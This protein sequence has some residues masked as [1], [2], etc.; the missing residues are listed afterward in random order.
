M[1]TDKSHN[2]ATVRATP[3]IKSTP[4]KHIMRMIRQNRIV[5]VRLSRK[6]SPY[7]FM[8][9]LKSNSA[10]QGGVKVVKWFMHNNGV[11]LFGLLETKLKPGNLLKKNTSICDGW[12]VSTNCSWHK[13]GRIWVLWKP[14]LFDIQFLSYSAQ[15]IHMLVHSQIDDKRFYLTFIYSYNDLN[16]RIELWHFLKKF[17][18]ECNAPWLWLGDFNTVLSPVER[19]GGSTSD[20]EMEHFQDCVSICCMEDIAATVALFTWSNKQAP[21]DRVYSRLDRAM[22]NQEWFEHFGDSVAHFHPEGL[23]ITVLV[24]LWTGILR[25]MIGNVSSILTC[26]GLHQL[27][28]LLCLLVGPSPIRKALIENP[29]DATLLQQELDLAHDLKD[30]ITARDSF[31]IQKVKVQWSLEGDLNTSYFHHSIKKRVM[32]KKVF[33]IE[34]KDGILCTDGDA[35]QNA[36]LVYYQELLG[37]HNTTDAV[38]INVVKQGQ[39]YNEAHWLLMSSPVTAEEVKKCL[40]NIPASKSPGPHGYS[41]QFYRDAWDIVGTE[42]CE[43]VINFFDTGKLLTQINATVITLIPKIDRPASVKHYRP[44]SCC[45]VLYKVISMLLCSRMALVLPDLISKTQG[46]FVKGR[47]I[48]ENILICQDLIRQY[49]RG[50]ASP[51]CLFKLDLQKAYDSIEWAFVDQMLEALHLPEKFRRMIMLC[52]TT[53][54]YTLNLNGAQFGYFHGRRGLRQG[55]PISL[56]IFCI[57]MEYLSRI[58]EYATRKCKGDVKSIMLILR[59]LATFS[60]SSGLKVNASNSEVVYNWVSDS[61]KH[62]IAQVSGFQEGKL[63]FKYLGIPIQ[64]GRLTRADCNILLENIISRIRGIG[65]RK[66][67]YAG[68]LVLINSVLNTLHNYW[69]SIFLIP[70]GVIKRLKSICRNF[71]WCGGSNYNRAPLVA[72]QNVCCSK[73]EGGLGIKEA[74]VWNIASVGKLVNWIYTKADR[75]WVLWIDHVYMKGADWETY[76]PPPDSNWNWRNICKVKDCL[77]GGYQGNCWVASTGGYSISAGYHCLQALHPP[78]PLYHDVWYTWVLPKQAFIGWL[79]HR[80]APNTRSKLCKLG[81]SS[82]ANCVVCEM[83]EETHDH[84]FWDCAYASKIIAGLENWLQLKLNDQSA[85]YSKLQKRV[86]RVVKMAV[87]YAIWMERNSARLELSIC[88]PEKL[89]QQVQNQVHGRLV[90]KL[91]NCTMPSECS[92][93]STINIRC[94][95][96]T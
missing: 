81:L 71:L 13:G 75:L 15:H 85:S 3:A 60:G 16:G 6:F 83:G 78:V 67:S 8:D 82:T 63:P 48:L 26:R 1:H 11:G 90:E 73:K 50:K 31:L 88:R 37:T 51:R 38:N 4:A 21:V 66:L 10:T 44:I 5:G 49:S 91:R 65:A 14:S 76:H 7:T 22:G 28:N 35:I 56:L 29:S 54:T 40:F 92:W 30:L 41:S 69:A 19:L 55:D 18:E 32:M 93:L 96:C 70:K 33:Q 36:F 64:H 79:I 89:I 84:L 68:R 42:I 45:N 52:I 53:P 25:L 12:S 74:G 59:V 23:F 39:C 95:F 58:M 77:A 27:L 80:N 34:D 86:C 24:Q 94:P 43:A 61:L 9:A 20:A 62:D 72:W 46:A 87:L 57:C 47:S 2:L 17:S